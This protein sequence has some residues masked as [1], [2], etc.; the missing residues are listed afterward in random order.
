MTDWL[1]HVGTHSIQCRSW[2]VTAAGRKYRLS[3]VVGQDPISE[4]VLIL[5]VGEKITLIEVPRKDPSK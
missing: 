4:I 2:E 5:P 1:V 3:G